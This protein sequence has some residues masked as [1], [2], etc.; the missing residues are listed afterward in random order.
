MVEFAVECW[1]KM[2]LT[3][4]PSKRSSKIPFQTSP[5]VRH[6]FRRKLRQLH[7]GNRWCL[8]FLL[9]FKGP[10]AKGG[11]VD[12]NGQRGITSVVRWN[13]RP[14]MFGVKMDSGTSLRY[15]VPIFVGKRLMGGQ[16]VSCD[17]GG[18]ETYHRVRPPKPVLEASESGI[19]LVC[20]GFL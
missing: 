5:E 9:I 4:F 10:E 3:I 16:N 15:A 19:C 13:P 11:F 6:Q 14:V 17:F 8:E 1:W 12:L 20:A 7:S 2:L 18:G